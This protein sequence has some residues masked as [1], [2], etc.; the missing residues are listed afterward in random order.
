MRLTSYYQKFIR[1]YGV[2]SRPLIDLLKKE[3]FHWNPQAEATLLTLKK[4]MTQALVLALP[5]FTKQFLVDTYACEKG[6]GAMLMQEGKPIA[7]ISQALGPKHLGWSVYD[8]ELL[9]VLK[10]VETLSRGQPICD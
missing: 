9:A 5:N 2:I 8:K 3:G 6:I 4:A 10:A 7:F 1:H